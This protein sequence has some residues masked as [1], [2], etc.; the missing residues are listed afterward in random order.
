MTRP[1]AAP[2]RRAISMPSTPV[3]DQDGADPI[4]ATP[5]RAA[6]A[7]F[8]WI[9]QL[10]VAGDRLRRRTSAADQA[11]PPGQ[12]T[13]G[14]GTPGLATSEPAPPAARR[15][16]DQTGN[17]RILS[18]DDLDDEALRPGAP[19]AEAPG[20]AQA[21]DPALDAQALPVPGYDALTLPSLRARLRNLDT[22]QLRVLIAYERSH[23]G[24]PDVITM[25]E[26]R[27][28]KL[29]GDQAAG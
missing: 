11:A 22:V 27:I 2:P 8:T 19:E 7:I 18:P 15:S 10:L 14:R 25:F 3:S 13:T 20:P 21:A 28:A 16:L 17:V 9:G 1:Q 24:R 29:A 12:A 4:R 26:R 23:A 6:R 5:A